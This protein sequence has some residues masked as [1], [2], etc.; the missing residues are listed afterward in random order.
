MD[1]ANQPGQQAPSRLRRWE[2]ALAT[3]LTVAIVCG[4][5]YFWRHVGGFWRDEVNTFN[6][7]SRP[8]LA[9]MAQDSF[10]V[11]MPLLLHGWMALGLDR[12]DAEVR[13]LGFG[14]G[15]GILAAIWFAGWKIHRSPPLLLLALLGANATLI[16][17]GD[18]LRAYGLGS[19]F[20]LLAVTG[21]IAFLR[22]PSWARA[23]GLALLF[24]LSV[25]TLYHNAILVGA[26]CAGAM[27][28]C[29]RQRNGKGVVQI[30]AAGTIAAM[31]LLPYVP[32]LIG[33]RDTAA[34]VRTG[35]T[36]SRLYGKFSDCLGFPFQFYILIWVLLALATVIRGFSTG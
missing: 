30:F 23:M 25:Q 36:F 31:T 26:I 33:A 35:A 12:T 14:V 16:V 5:V 17:Y 28:V 8:S 13:L 34:V 29:L 6:L 1:A 15:L 27:A 19:L 21:A 22:K 11:L 20:I 2:W 32:M 10:P 18:A 9:A 7:A 3:A 4:H 24:V